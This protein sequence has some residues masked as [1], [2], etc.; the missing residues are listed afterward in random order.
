M[1]FRDNIFPLNMPT[2][3][4]PIQIT[5]QGPR[6]NEEKYFGGRSQHFYNNLS[7][8]P[9]RKNLE[10]NQY[11]SAKRPIKTNPNRSSNLEFCLA[12]DDGHVNLHEDV[13][14][15]KL[16]ITLIVV[17]EFNLTIFCIPCHIHQKQFELS[18]I[19]K[20]NYAP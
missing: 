3:S 19:Y 7:P 2:V 10:R 6:N 1:C 14:H 9:A 16:S 18:S 13:A 5:T 11:G 15:Q 20:H 8:L 4:S 12:K 17:V